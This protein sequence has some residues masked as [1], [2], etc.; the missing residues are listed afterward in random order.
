MNWAWATP[1]EQIWHSPEFPMWAA[2]AAAGFFALILLVILVRAERSVAN[3]ALAV[4]TLLA[5]GI[6]VTATIRGYGP[7][8]RNT[9]SMER[10][11]AVTAKIGRA[12]V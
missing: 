10:R 9:A 1:L 8:A 7:L 4:I 11:P 2:L 5:V 12:H 6:A 3:G